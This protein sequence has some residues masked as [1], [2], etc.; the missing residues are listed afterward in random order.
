M[1][2]QL[3]SLIA[4]AEGGD[5]SAADALFTTLYDELHS[6]ARRQLSPSPS[7]MTLGTT[8][9]LHQAFAHAPAVTEQPELV[10][11]EGGSRAPAPAQRSAATH[12]SGWAARS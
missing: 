6:L 5:R 3:L 8:T 2:L 10:V 7:E 12:S 9:L 11:A 1:R 4:A